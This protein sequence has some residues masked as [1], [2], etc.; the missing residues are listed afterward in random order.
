MV[1]NK[2]I[3]STKFN[4]KGVLVVKGQ[5]LSAK[6]MRYNLLERKKRG[7]RYIYWK[8]SS[9]QQLRELERLG[10]EKEPWFYLIH[11]RT[12]RNIHYVKASILKDVHYANKK[13]QTTI[14][15]RLKNGEGRILTECGIK[16]E[17]IKYRIDL[18]TGPE[19]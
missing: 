7:E 1:Y 6:K 13:G 3:G 11:T 4:L 12:F 2:S 15:R 19:V 5:A 14:V 10:F 17:P 8:I 9:T 18:R 16:F